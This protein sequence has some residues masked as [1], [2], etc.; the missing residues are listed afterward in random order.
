MVMVPLDKPRFSGEPRPEILPSSCAAS[1]KPIEM[2]APT[3]AERPTRK[4]VHG[5]CVA[6][7]VAKIGARVETEP[8]ISPA[9]PGWTQVSRNWR[10]AAASSAEVAVVFL[11]LP[12]VA[13][14]EGY[15]RQNI[16]L[17]ANQVALLAAVAQANPNVVVVLSNGSAVRV[18]N[19]QGGAR[20]VLEGWLLGQAGG[21]AI[22]DI[23]F[24][25]ANPSGRLTETIPEKLEDNSAFLD[26]PGRDG[27]LGYG[28][29]VFV[30]YRWY[31]ARE[32]PV[33]YPFGHGLSYTSFEY[34]GLS[35]SVDGADADLS[36]HVSVTVTNTGSVA[37]REVVQLYVSAPSA[38]VRRPLNELRGFRAVPLEPGESREV[39]FT[40]GFRDFAYFHPTLRSWYVENGAV[41]I[42]VGASSRDIRERGSVEV[43]VD[44]PVVPLDR[45]SSLAE[46]T[47][48]PGGSQVL[49]GLL[50]QAAAQ[51]PDAVGMFQNEE[52]MAMMGSMPLRRIGRF[53]GVGLTDEQIDGLIAQANALAEVR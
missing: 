6:K 41:D 13:E 40:L 16:D 46:W 32:L 34:S 18:S 19:W 15:D 5:F 38:Q 2:P 33:S 27:H 53:P 8:S 7:A 11:G 35:M 17:P 10:C 3:E 20:A 48:H 42:L 24:G 51:N 25:I 12:S 45:Q 52:L 4:V 9:R 49:A 14:S 23:L 21:G 22:A 37:G 29:G 50:Q 1:V 39:S 26:F 28:D 44:E 31:D 43:R 47:K 36:V 30:G